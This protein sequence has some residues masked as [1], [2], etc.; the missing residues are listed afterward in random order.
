MYKER[1]EKFPYLSEEHKRKISCSL[2]GKPGRFKNKHHTIETRQK[3]SKATSGKNN[4]NWKDGISYEPYCPKWTPDLR[5][6]IR[7]FFNYECVLC[8]KSQNENITKTGKLYQLHCHHVEYNKMACCDGNPIHFAALCNS[9]HAK[10]NNNRKIWEEIL[11]RII[12]EIY[13]GHSYYTKNEWNI[14][15]K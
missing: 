14:I 5:R 13:N 10:T 11:H 12:N 6:R 2:L 1:H 4:P 15:K 7:A 8:G 3:I 9:C